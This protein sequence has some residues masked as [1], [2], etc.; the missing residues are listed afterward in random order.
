MVWLFHNRD[1]T[2]NPGYKTVNT[3]CSCRERL[4][5]R[6]RGAITASCRKEPL[7]YS[8]WQPMLV[9]TK[10]FVRRPVIELRQIVHPPQSLFY[11][12]GQNSP[13]LL[14][15]FFDEH[16][17]IISAGR[18]SGPRRLNMGMHHYD[19][20]A[21]QL[22]EKIIEKVKGGERRGERRGGVCSITSS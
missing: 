1:G 15:G 7:S 18:G 10:N 8:A 11:F 13:T 22:Q 12:R 4:S 2:K 14:R 3:G 5:R 17:W 20:V 6:R 9:V 16:Y 21:G 19:I